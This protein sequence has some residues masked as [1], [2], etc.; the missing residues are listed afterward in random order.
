MTTIL[1]VED[2]NTLG[3]TL[4]MTLESAGHEV[5]WKTTL[6]DARKTL[7]STPPDLLMLDLGLPDGDGIALCKELRTSGSTTPILIL[8]AR[9]TLVSRVTGLREGAD[10][11]VTKPFELPE[12]MARVEVLLRRQRWNGPGESIQVGEL[13]LELKS[14]RGKRDGNDVGMTDL[15]FRLL[16][17]LAERPGQVL[18]RKT[19][20]TEVWGQHGETQTRTIDVF[21]GRLRKYVETDPSSP[22]VLINVRG[23]GYRLVLG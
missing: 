6:E 9:D 17:Y 19:L 5:I 7:Q 23:V 20:L 2:D 8:T 11:Y 18:S 4:E 22:K 10:D 14:R 15:E 1:L 3:L 16:H 12:L 21:M 13:C